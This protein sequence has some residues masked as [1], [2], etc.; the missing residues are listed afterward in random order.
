M[1]HG[2]FTVLILI[3][4]FSNIS[5][6]TEDPGCTVKELLQKV[7]H[8]EKTCKDSFSTYEHK[9]YLWK[10][11]KPYYYKAKCY[12]FKYL[13]D[14]KCQAYLDLKALEKKPLYTLKAYKDAIK[15]KDTYTTKEPE[16][17]RTAI[18]GST[19]TRDSCA[20]LKQEIISFSHSCKGTIEG[21]EVVI[22]TLEK[23]YKKL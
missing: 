6:S 18:E 20:K 11:T 10:D 2:I 5:Y 22:G 12:L 19:L 15:E 17:L 23:L 14:T 21:L 16:N 13:G 7:D 9:D 3:F 8:A 4:C 1:K